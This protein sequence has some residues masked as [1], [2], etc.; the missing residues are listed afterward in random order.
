VTGAKVYGKRVLH[1]V[2]RRAFAESAAHRR[3]LDVLGVFEHHLRAR[4]LYASER[5]IIDGLLRECYRRGDGKFDSLL[6][7]SILDREY[8]A[9]GPV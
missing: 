5:L 1:M 7:M 4:R 3:W 6:V 2:K 9:Q 8:L